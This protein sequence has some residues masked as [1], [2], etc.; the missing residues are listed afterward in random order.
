MRKSFIKNSGFTLIETIVSLGIG[1]LVMTMIMSVITPGFK[2]IREIR[3][4]EDL[5]KNAVLII[6]KLNYLIKKSDSL[7][8]IPP[9]KLT[10]RPEGV[11]ETIEIGGSDIV[12]DGVPL[13]TDDVKISALQ[14][15]PM[16]KSVVIE[17]RIESAKG[18]ASDDIK[19]T[20]ARRN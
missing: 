10:I 12:L 6:N 18:N 3:E 11:D 5:H 2:N 8:V 4:K 19:T 15:T 7:A 14:F 16:S 9:D 1:I 17:F 20:I 13:N